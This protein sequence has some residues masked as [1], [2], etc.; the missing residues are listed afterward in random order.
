MPAPQGTIKDYK[1]YSSSLKEEMELLIYFPESFSPLYK[2][3]VVIAQDGRDYFQ[4][5]RIGRVADELLYQKEIQ[6]IIIVGIPYKNVHDRRSKYHPEGDKQSAYIRFLA[7]ELVPYLDQSFPTYSMAKGRVLIGDSLGATVALQAALKYPHTFGHVIMQSPFVNDTVMLAA[8]EF[9]DPSL[10]DIYH[11]IGI[12]ETDVPTTDGQKQNFIEP[13]RK[14]NK[15]LS[16]RNFS[17]FYKEFEGE[18]TWKFWQKDLKRA[19]I[20]T[21]GI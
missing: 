4:L 8:E 19:L 2:Y 20:N 3:T 18:H 11:V 7:H 13:N 9:A 15:L 1:L 16:R 14:L 5:G 17:F 12:R 21:L 10:L 6:N